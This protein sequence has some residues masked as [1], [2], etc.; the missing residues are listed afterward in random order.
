MSPSP[1]N[2]SGA[3]RR[4][5]Q[6][7]LAPAIAFAV[8]YSAAWARG[9]KP[10]PATP[11]QKAKP[12]PRPMRPEDLT[13]ARARW[14]VLGARPLGMYY[15][16]GDSRALDSLRNNA[17][18][19]TLLAPQCFSLDADGIV[20]GQ[21]PPPVTEIARRANLPLMPL[22]VNPGFDRG[23]ARAVLR[24]PKAQ[25]RV[26]AY[27]AY[28]AHRDNYLGWQLDLEFLDPADKD[29]YSRFV[30]RVAAR[31]HQDR[32]LLSVAVVPRFSDVYPGTDPTGEFHTSE[33]GAPFDYRAL[34]R[35]ADFLT[36]MTYDHHHGD[37][38]PGPIAGHDW[39][40]A[41]LEYALARVPRAKLL[42]G[43]PFYGREWI[44]NG[45]ATTTRSLA[46]KDASDLLQQRQIEPQWD[47][48]WQT[49][50]FQFRDAAGLHTAWF[51]DRRSLEEKLKLMRQ[52]QLRG[53]AAWRL[54]VEDPQFWELAE[55]LREKPPRA[56]PA[57]Q[58]KRKER[59]TPGSSSSRSQ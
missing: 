19:M 43:I 5:A 12:A 16:T 8:L 38:P 36:V 27:L 52:F 58:G 29:L 14:R 2:A 15:Y 28:L 45:K 22:V 34:G 41:A 37:G 10:A 13:L 7:L 54:G 21:V 42:L 49:P 55:A 35:V 18:E 46:F 51:E 26:I 1:Q 30:A 20:R 59:A 53:F 11:G 44:Q 39:V 57:T 9:Q 3:S 6:A 40:R 33:W 17:V 24:N 48:R 47:T 50:W 25:E 4:F 23:I 31:L 56:H 32:R